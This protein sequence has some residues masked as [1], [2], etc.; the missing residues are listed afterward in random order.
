MCPLVEPL[1]INLAVEPVLH[2]KIVARQRLFTLGTGEAS[3]VK[4]SASVNLKIAALNPCVTVTAK[5][6]I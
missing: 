1:C 5:R 4:P 3:G 6:I 2:L